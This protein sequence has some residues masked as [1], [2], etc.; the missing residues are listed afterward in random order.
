[1]PE[2]TATRPLPR[3]CTAETITV[4][5]KVEEKLRPDLYWLSDEW[6]ASYA[7]RS[8]VEAAFGLLKGWTTGA[9][10]RGWTHQVGLVRTSLLLALGVAANN[11]TQLLLWAKSTGDTHDEITQM[12]VTCYGF[13][14]YDENGNL[15]DAGA[16]PDGR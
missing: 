5:S 11:L 8:R 4:A 16:P 10:R 12:D 6:I 7:R 15:P 2:V 14:D 1:M 9:V 13:A 3:A